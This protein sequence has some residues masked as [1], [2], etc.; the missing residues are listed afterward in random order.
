[1]TRPA[2][3]RAAAMAF[4]MLVTVAGVAVRPPTAAADDGRGD[5]RRGCRVSG[6]APSSISV[7]VG[8]ETRTALVHVPADLNRRRRAPVVL[9]FHGFDSSAETQASFDGMD[10]TADAN[11]FVSVH[12]QGRFA[13][14]YPGISGVGWDIFNPASPDP[15]FVRALLDERSARVCVDARRVY[16]TGLSNG[17]G[18]ARFLGCTRPDRIAAVSAIAGDTPTPCAGGPAIPSLSFH[19]VDDTINQYFV[20]TPTFNQLPIETWVAGEAER[21]GCETGPRVRA[22]TARVELLRWRDCDVP[23]VLYRLREHAHT[24][25]GR[26]YGFTREDLIAFGLRPELA[27]ALTIRNDDIDATQLSWE[28]FRRFSLDD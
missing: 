7:Q 17:G 14:V 9:T 2:S 18:V 11:G 19:G 5:D 12:P 13:E 4:S 24:W 21:N 6:A 28:F 22:V 15:A 23:T 3:R 16:A 26:S 20:P 27:D 1:M 25:P 8:G 10:A